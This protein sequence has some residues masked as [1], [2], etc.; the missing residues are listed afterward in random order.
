MI[1]DGSLGGWRDNSD[2]TPRRVG[3]KLAVLGLETSPLLVIIFP[4]LD[5]L[6]LP[7]AQIQLG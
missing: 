6:V 3:S 4:L 1:A 2:F 5:D 7:A